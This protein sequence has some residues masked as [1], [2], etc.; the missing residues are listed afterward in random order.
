MAGE[1]FYFNYLDHGALDFIGDRESLD[2][3]RWILAL[4]DESRYVW[5][6]FNDTPFRSQGQVV[7]FDYRNKIDSALSRFV[8]VNRLDDG[9]LIKM[10][11]PLQ[12]DYFECKLYDLKKELY[13]LCSNSTLPLFISNDNFNENM[14]SYGSLVCVD[15]KGKERAFDFDLKEKNVI[16]YFTRIK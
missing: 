4:N 6:R 2:S 13:Y 1:P 3:C 11:N 8:L 16:S 14:F 9:Y 10:N 5:V 15:S 12:S 7:Y